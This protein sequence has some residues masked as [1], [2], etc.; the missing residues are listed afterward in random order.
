MAKGF[1]E[2]AKLQDEAPVRSNAEDAK[3]KAGLEAA[4][5]LA[6]KLEASGAKKGTVIKDF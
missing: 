6:M 1:S 2:L 4:K 3:M 5:K